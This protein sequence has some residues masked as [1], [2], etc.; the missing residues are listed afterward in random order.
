MPKLNCHRRAR[1]AGLDPETEFQE[2][3]RRLGLYEFPWDTTQALS[4][5]L[6]RT[7]AV[8]SIGRLLA[9]TH[10]FTEH[11]QKR[12]DDT[13]LL[14][15]DAAIEDLDSP[16]GRAAVRRINQMHRMY[17]ISNDD[18][19]YVLSTFVVIPR[20]WNQEFGWR[21][22][23]SDEQ[24]AA[25][26]YYQALGKRMGIKDI[27][28]T[29]EEFEQLLDTYE[30]EHFGYDEGGR[31][32]A[33]STLELLTTFYPR[34]LAPLI[35]IFSLSLMEPHLL[36]AFGYPE[37]GRLPRALSRGAL[38]ARARVVAL[39]PARRK[40]A[41]VRDMPRIRSY[42][43]GFDTEAL[44]TFAP[45]CPVHRTADQTSEPVEGTKP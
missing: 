30:A 17:D 40:P 11:T 6:F 16:R 20:R 41:Y 14:L 3:S 13:A 42:P 43:H 9:D 18:M 44:G 12:Y 15:E 36:E 4:F 34:P 2:I 21:Q 22:S 27:P 28:A 32:V 7:Y 24:L 25:L 5:A 10:Q 8:P 37:P 1:T 39:L 38:K 35:R 19:R 29:Y 33:D 23:T 31:A 45:G 26:R